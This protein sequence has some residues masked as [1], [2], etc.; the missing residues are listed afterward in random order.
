MKTI[1][2]QHSPVFVRNF[3]IKGKLTN[4]GDFAM[5]L[6]DGH[7]IDEMKAL[8]AVKMLTWTTYWMKINLTQFTSF[9]KGQRA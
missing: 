8:C 1:F 7:V 5:K 9:D 6:E 4:W 3:R 2:Q